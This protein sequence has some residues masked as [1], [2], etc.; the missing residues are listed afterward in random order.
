M[1][2]LIVENVSMG[3]EK[4]GF[5]DKI[6]LTMFSVLPT[7]YSRHIL[8]LTPKK[9]SVKL[10]NERY[11]K[12]DFEKNYDIVHINFTNST[13]PHAYELADKFRE[14][15]STVVLS[16]LHPSAMPDEALEHADSVLLGQIGL[17]WLEFLKNYKK[18]KLKKIYEPVKLKN[19]QLKIPTTKIDLPGFVLSGAIEATRGCPYGCN[20]CRETNIP[21]GSQFLTRPVND[22]IKEIKNLPQ[23]AFTFYDTSLTINPSYTKKLFREMKNLGKVFS[24]NG[25]VDIL[26]KDKE[27]LKLAK[28]AG[29]ISWLVGFESASQETLDNI[30]KKTNKITEYSKAV[31]NI[32][33][34]GMA[35][36]GCFIIGFDSDTKDTFRLTL[37]TA[38]KIKID[39]ADF[40]VLT[41]FPGTL[42]YKKLKSE[43]RILTNDWSRYNMRNVVFKPKNM[44]K[45]ELLHGVKK[46][47]KDFYSF[48]NTSYR[49]IRSIKYG[50]YPFVIVLERNFFAHMNK[51]KIK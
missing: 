33:N 30:G 2:I 5:F 32:H 45:K 38:K 35:T 9:H 14:K 10:V 17:N 27:F 26:A 24:C 21:G 8:S 36:I 29:C 46:V 28:E 15:G 1:N 41:P 43:N 34:Y 48:K 23:K 25:N 19:K 7:L 11:E 20:F 51:R 37:D 4:Y 39:A 47:Y 16:G 13:A 31:E 49:T 40:L 6:F 3:K 42:L 44:S 50:F 12:I 22:V 18:N